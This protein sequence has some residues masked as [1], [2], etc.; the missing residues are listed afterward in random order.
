MIG[1]EDKFLRKTTLSLPTIVFAVLLGT[2]FLSS[3]CSPRA[4]LSPPSA[5]TPIEPS[6]SAASEASDEAIPIG[7]LL[8][9]SGPLAWVS[10]CIPAMDFAVQEVNQAGGAAGIPL[11]LLVEDSK[12]EVPASVS[13]ATKLF[14]VDE[15]VALVGPTS[16][17][18]REILPLAEQRKLIAVSP[19]A[20]TTTM[21]TL[22]GEYVFRTVSSDVV[23]G[24][25]M[26]W[27]AAHELGAR[28]VAFF[29]ADTSSANSIK[30]VLKAAAQ[31]LEMEVVADV[32]FIDDA[33]SY[34][35]ELVE[36]AVATPDVIFFEAGPESAEVFFRQQGEMGLQGTWIGTDY[37]ND[38]FVAATGATSDGVMAVNPAPL[39]T[40]RYAAWKATLES[41][42]GEAGVPAFSANAYDT[43]IVLALAIEAAG[44]PTREGIVANFRRVAGPP[45]RPVTSF[46]Q[47][48]ALL[49][50]GEDIDY[51]GLAGSQD[52]N[53]FGDVITS[54]Q[55]VIVKKGVIERIGSL[56]EA[57]I[58]DTLQQ[59]RDIMSR[60]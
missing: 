35:A 12:A 42:R 20:G 29:F 58:G 57:E 41:F 22:G 39:L 56:T 5:E 1:K 16:M 44:E 10:N 26:A 49:Q 59:V 7:V 43:I 52:F 40:E 9:A 37:M 8:A 6:E 18:I 46:E 31:T 14:D 60:E 38:P 17:T 23:M 27:Y 50:A 11:K 30:G 51:V 24:T 48:K 15:V 13:A 4:I 34:R 53:S 45:G 33:P 25:G 54:L 3:A 32:L 36:L 28:K 47:G 19:V 2:T 21:D 55:I